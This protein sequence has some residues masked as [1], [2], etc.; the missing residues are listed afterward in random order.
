MLDVSVAYNRYRFL[1]L[2]FLTWLW[3]IVATKTGNIFPDSETDG[4]LFIG[5]RM[6]LENR[7]TKDIETIT[8]KGDQ[9]DLK[10]GAVALSKGALVS[11]LGV[12]YQKDGQSWRFTLK[13]E[14]LGITGLK[15]PTSAA[16]I[17]D[18]TGGA[19]L[20]K[21]YLCETVFKLTETI[22]SR[23]IQVRISDDW[24]KQ[25]RP[26]MINWIKKR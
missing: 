7:H 15:T 18:D 26:S 17:D 13:G 8:I 5:D 6:V 11:E 3:F 23:F 1:G 16:P 21:V 24:E 20:E 12:V 19:V 22:F 10:E 4:V 25:I 9:A 2:E 14:N